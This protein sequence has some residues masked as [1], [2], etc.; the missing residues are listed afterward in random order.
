MAEKLYAEIM[1]AAQNKGSA[2][3]KEKTLI[4]WPSQTKPLLISDG[5]N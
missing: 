4:K 3:K 1:D 2:I 5:K